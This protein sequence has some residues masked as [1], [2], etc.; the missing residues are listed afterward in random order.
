MW[1]KLLVRL[2]PGF[3]ALFGLAARLAAESFCVDP[4]TGSDFGPGSLARPFLTLEKALETVRARVAQGQRSDRIHPRTGI[5]RCTSTHTQYWL[6]LVGT[7]AAP[8]LL[9][10]MPADAGVPGAVQRPS[11][12]WYEHVVFD[13][14]WIIRTPWVRAPEH[15]G[16]W[17]TEPQF[18]FN[19]WPAD[20]VRWALAADPLPLQAPGVHRFTLAPY[21]LRQDGRPTLWAR[22]LAEIKTAG[23]RWF[24]FMTGRL[25][26]RPFDN[27]DPN[28]CS[29]ESWYGGP[30]RNGHL[31]RD[32]EGR[33]LFDGDLEHAEIRGFDFRMLTRTFEFHR[34]GYAS[35]RERVRQRHVLL[36]DNA[37]RYCFIHL[38]LDANT[39]LPGVERD[40]LLSPPNFAERSQWTV[41]H[42]PFFRP[43][44][45]CFQVHGE[46]H[47]F[48]SNEIMEHGGPWAGPAARVGAVNC[49]NMPGAIVRHNFVW[50][51]GANAWQSGSVFMIEAQGVSHADANGDNVFGG[52]IYEHNLFAGIDPGP[53]LVLG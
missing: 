14:G 5:Y 32:G 38:L 15:P 3:V 30:D 31:L 27:R 44:K 25:Y 45:E 10:A 22:G 39:V 34:R 20:K 35:E 16:V 19:E 48:E 49:R 36:E 4:R 18:H 23:D 26:L 12:R 7:P 46:G 43:T 53:T 29:L 47:V 52:Q 13:D 17:R 37:W 40:A 50:G 11:G 21:M 1:R 8:A 41:R 24:D 42:N 9:S 6:T 28:T 51:H 2:A 33:G